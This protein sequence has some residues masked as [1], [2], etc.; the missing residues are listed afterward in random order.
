MGIMNQVTVHLLKMK[1]SLLIGERPV[2]R[3]LGER[4]KPFVPGLK[5]PAAWFL[6]MRFGLGLNDTDGI[7]KKR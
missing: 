3:Q 5:I 4:L 2:M 7:L 6:L 1:S